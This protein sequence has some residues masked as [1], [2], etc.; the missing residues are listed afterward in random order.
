MVCL[1]GV[2]GVIDRGTA[3]QE[4]FHEL[5]AAAGARPVEEDAAGIVLF[6]QGSAEGD[7]VLRGKR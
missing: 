5:L 6:G 3:L 4:P 1:L 7:E 2:V